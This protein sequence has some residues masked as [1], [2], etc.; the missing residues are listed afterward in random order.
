MEFYRAEYLIENLK[1]HSEK[2]SES[3]R[4]DEEQQREQMQ[5]NNPSNMMREAQRSMPKF[6]APSF[7]T[8]KFKF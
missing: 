3:R 4:K 5:Q 6:N 7:T 2:E 1:N 8:P